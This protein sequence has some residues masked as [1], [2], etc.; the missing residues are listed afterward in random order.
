M[1]PFQECNIQLI[2]LT[3]I[4][5]FFRSRIVFVV[6]ACILLFIQFMNVLAYCTQTSLPLSIIISMTLKVV[7]TL[8]QSIKEEKQG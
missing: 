3:L 4:S 6:Y 5:M 8:V 2:P 1:T 7:L